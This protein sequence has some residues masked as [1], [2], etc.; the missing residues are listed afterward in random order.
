MV[1]AIGLILGMQLLGEGIARLF[2]LS[3][4]GPVIGLVL[5]ALLLWRSNALRATVAPV[6][7]G[8]LLHLSLLFVPAAVGV[9]QHVGVFADAFIPIV[10]ALCVSTAATL[11]VSVFVF[12][13]V[14]RRFGRGK[15]IAAGEDA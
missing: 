3:L 15:A 11:V 10:L 8:L 13:W 9:M 5:L 4:P 7:E 2:G 12:V 1:N 14:D 6:A